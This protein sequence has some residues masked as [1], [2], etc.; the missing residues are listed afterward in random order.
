MQVADAASCRTPSFNRLTAELHPVDAATGRQHS[1]RGLMAKLQNATG[2]ASS[3]YRHLQAVCGKAAKRNRCCWKRGAQM[4]PA[5]V[6]LLLVMAAVLQAG[7]DVADG[8]AN[9]GHKCEPFLLQPDTT[10]G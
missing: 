2:D 5:R 8:A 1:C 4:L 7:L 9:E 3:D 6:V 10:Y